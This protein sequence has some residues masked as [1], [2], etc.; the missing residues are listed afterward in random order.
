MQRYASTVSTTGKEFARIDFY[1]HER[2]RRL[3][4]MRRPVKER[5]SAFRALC[6]ELYNENMAL[7]EEIKSLPDLSEMTRTIVEICRDKVMQE[8]RQNDL[9]T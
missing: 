8:F 7:R 2:I 4:T 3:A 1:W 6:S 5:F 9:S